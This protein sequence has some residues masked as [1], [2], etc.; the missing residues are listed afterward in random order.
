LAQQRCQTLL[1]AWK[2]EMYR[3][4]QVGPACLAVCCQA[5]PKKPRVLPAAV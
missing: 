4:F 1:W 5:T 2:C 3:Q